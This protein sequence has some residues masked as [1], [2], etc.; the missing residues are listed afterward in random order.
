[1]TTVSESDRRLNAQG[2]AAFISIAVVSYLILFV[3]PPRPYSVADAAALIVLGLVYVLIGTAGLHLVGRIDRFAAVLAY[4]AV[5]IILA[6]IIM[7][8]AGSVGQMWL[9]PLP[10]VSQAVL[11]LPRRWM[12]VVCLAILGSMILSAS[13]AG[14]R[15]A[16]LQGA[17][18]FAAAVGFVALFTQIAASERNARSEVETL[19]AQLG[20]ANRRL[21]EYAIQAEDLATMQERNRLAR[22][23]HDGL[24]HYLTVINIQL[25]AARAVMD[26][27]PERARSAL[28]KAQSL[29]QQALAEVRRSVATLRLSPTEARP[30]SDA[31]KD[32]IEESRAAGI[33][34][35]FHVIGE[36]RPLSP[37]ATL[38]LYRAA[39]EGLTN[40]R[41]HARAS[42]ADVTLDYSTAG[43]VRLRVKDNG[44]GAAETGTGFGLLGLRE[45]AQVLGGRV[46]IET[47]PRQGF[48]LEVETP[49]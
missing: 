34:T 22:D 44:I 25:E 3:G 49:G 30:L 12:V 38:T 48:M 42:R 26:T 6:T 13:I 33:V 10:L 20:E 47:A 7:V 46:S 21:R 29:T 18:S 1:M 17:I 35:E 39:Q 2:N 9:L 37:Q 11:I 28:E 23:I 43:C 4:F 27:D 24:G 36:Q 16:L 5:E 15:D 41:K 31:I 19:A 40:V 32:M 8:A 14:Q 45:R